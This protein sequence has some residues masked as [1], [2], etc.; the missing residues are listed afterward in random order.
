[1]PADVLTVFE[2]ASVLSFG[3]AR[4]KWSQPKYLNDDGTK[5]S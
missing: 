4:L 1:M 2:R 3:W 5:A